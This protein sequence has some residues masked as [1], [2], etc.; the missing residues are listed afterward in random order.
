VADDRKLLLGK[1]TVL[2]KDWI[3][4][5]EFFQNGTVNWRDTK[6]LEK[7]TGRWSMG[8]KLVNLSW[9]DSMTKESWQLP[10]SP[11]ANKRTWYS[12]PSY[13]TGPY[14]IEKVVSPL[15]PN[16]GVDSD[17]DPLPSG[18][19]YT[20]KSEY[21]DNVQSAEYNPASGT[22]TV[23]HQD[24]TDL[25]LD[26]LKILNRPTIVP[27][28][29]DDSSIV[30]M[31]GSSIADL[32][33]FYRSRKNGKIFPIVMDDNSIPNIVAMIRQIQV[34]LPGAVALKQIGR[35]ILD[36]V[37]LSLL[38]PDMSRG[39]GRRAFQARPRNLRENATGLV[40]SLR[41]AG[42]KV[43]VNIGGTGEIADAINLNPNRVAPRSGIPNLAQ[44]WG[45]RIGEL[46][47]AGTVDEI[48][49]NRLPPDTIGWNQ[50]I[51]GAYNVLKQGGRIVLKFQGGGENTK[52][53][54][55]VMKSVGFR[56]INEVPGALVEAIK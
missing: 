44:T 27:I 3:W 12:A 34:A 7:G 1:W 19:D 56:D 52:M 21:I 24:G 8:S 26:I 40:R 18:P 16:L 11:L 35:S 6:R 55:E 20:K 39:L 23:K 31:P 28:V 2:V 54:V 46:F 32:Y 41:S 49:S 25:E 36:I 10:L 38:R 53:I 30:Q 48:T 13:Y 51:P 47:D 33:V 50:V 5:Y 37:E 9:F 43:Q 4:E 29:I 22:F 15:A 42:K 17:R 14:Q 45:E